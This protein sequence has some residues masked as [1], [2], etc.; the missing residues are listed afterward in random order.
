MA[1]AAINRAPNTKSALFR[2]APFDLVVLNA[3]GE[4]RTVRFPSEHELVAFMKATRETLAPI[5]FTYSDG[6]PLDR[7]TINRLHNSFFGEIQTMPGTTRAARA[8]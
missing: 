5:A 7:K 2:R 8:L 3:A 1:E 4:Q 6:S